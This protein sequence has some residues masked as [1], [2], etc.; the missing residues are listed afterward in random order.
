MPA[1][2]RTDKP[3][4]E[5]RRIAANKS[6]FDIG[7]IGR[8]PSRPADAPISSGGTETGEHRI[9]P[10]EVGPELVNKTLAKALRDRSSIEVCPTKA[11]QPDSPDTPQN[12]AE[13]YSVQ[14]WPGTPADRRQKHRQDH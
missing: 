4:W 8:P 13:M 9:H 10:I 12:C 14:G 1:I 5:S 3:A 11:V 2:A 6:T 7:A